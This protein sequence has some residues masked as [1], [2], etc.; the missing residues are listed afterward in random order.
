MVDHVELGTRNGEIV[1]VEYG[2]ICKPLNYFVIGLHKAGS[3]LLNSYIH[4]LCTEV[5]VSTVNVEADIFSAGEWSTE[6]R[7]QDIRALDRIGYIY[8]S[9]RTPCIVRYMPSYRNSPKLLLV[10]DLRDVAVSMYFSFLYS[11]GSPG[12]GSAGNFMARMKESFSK[13]DVSGAVLDGSMDEIFD[14]ALEFCDHVA[15]LSNFTVFRYEDVVFE[16]STWVRQIADFL[17]FAIDQNRLDEISAKFDVIPAE[18]NIYSH[19]R[20]VKPGN[21][22]YHLNVDAVKYIQSGYIPFFEDFGYT[23]D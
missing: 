20:Q 11:H 15:L 3:V 10:R 17:D 4:E 13:K 23:L 5:G 18:E 12:R 14:F 2:P 9:F 8:S 1:K 21:Y 19:V 6:F 22:K 7:K 16:K